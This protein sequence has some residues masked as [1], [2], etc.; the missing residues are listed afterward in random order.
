MI[1]KEEFLIGLKNQ[2]EDADATN[3]TFESKFKELDTWDSLTR[4]S[5]VAFVED[6]YSIAIS[7]EEFKSFETPADLFAYISNKS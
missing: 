6:D 1:N 2:F 5:I 3:L 4:F 7:D